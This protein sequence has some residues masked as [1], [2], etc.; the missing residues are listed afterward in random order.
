MINGY[1]I[2]YNA[3]LIVKRMEYSSEILKFMFEQELNSR[4]EKKY[5]SRLIEH[6]DNLLEIGK[7]EEIIEISKVYV[8]NIEKRHNFLLITQIFPKV[9]ELDRELV[10]KNAAFRDKNG[11]Y[12]EAYYYF[13]DSF[14]KSILIK[15][16]KGDTFSSPLSLLFTYFKN[17]INKELK[18]TEHKKKQ[19]G[20]VERLLNI[21]FKTLF[22]EISNIENNGQFNIRDIFF[23]KDWKISSENKGNIVPPILLDNFISWY[24]T[25][26]SISQQPGDYD[27]DMTIIVGI[28]FPGVD[29]NLFSMFLILNKSFLSGSGIVEEEN[30]IEERLRRAIKTN[31]DFYFMDQFNPYQIPLKRGESIKLIFEYFYKYFYLIS[32]SPKDISSEEVS[33]RDVCKCKEEIIKIIRKRKLQKALDYL[34]S[35]EVIDL[36]KKEPYFEGN[37]EDLVTL[38]EKLLEYVEEN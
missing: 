22:E 19:L 11:L 31:K 15:V 9:L 21:F 8:E 2:T 4:D 5:N 6:L 13:G 23:P 36:S 18:E 34:K 35:K 17:H 14:L 30:I 37:R 1:V 28:I 33:D 25:R 3:I 7:Y 16:F 10:Q 12:E 24:R 26:K 27:K 29:P 20:D 32:V 38:I